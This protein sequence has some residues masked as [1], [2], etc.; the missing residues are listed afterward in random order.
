MSKILYVT[1]LFAV[2]CYYSLMWRVK[3]RHIYFF[4][5]KNF[6]EILPLLL[7]FFFCGRPWRKEAPHY[8]TLAVVLRISGDVYCGVSV[9][10]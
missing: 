2:Y 8:F 10:E 5:Q 9:K 6:Q 3:N 1:D 7:G 4:Y